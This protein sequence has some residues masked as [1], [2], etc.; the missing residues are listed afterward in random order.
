MPFLFSEVG[1]D[2]APTRVR[3][4]SHLD[5]PALLAPGGD[6]GRDW[7]ELC[8]EAVPA[9]EHRPTALA[10]GTVG[11]AYLCHPFLVHSAQP[12]RGRQ[13]RFVAQPPLHARTPL[14]LDEADPPPV[15]RSVLNG[16]S[17]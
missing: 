12:H 13:P 7:M 1:P 10:T 14:D 15:A 9:S 17:R 5:V 2:D 11:D 8:A 4:G 16:L 6:E 3:V